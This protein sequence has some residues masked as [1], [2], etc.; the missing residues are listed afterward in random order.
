[1]KK[2]LIVPGKG[3]ESASGADNPEC[4]RT[5]THGCASGRL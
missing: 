5:D 2:P 1:M 4:S 3:R